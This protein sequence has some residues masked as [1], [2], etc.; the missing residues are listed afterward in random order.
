[1]S[2]P[3]IPPATIAKMASLGLSE[4]QVLD[5]FA[6]GEQKTAAGGGTMMVKKY[7]GYEVGLFYVRNGVTGEYVITTVWK[8][9]RR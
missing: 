7:N 4:A 8:R 9:D 5:V 1:M 2:T 6:H 3:F